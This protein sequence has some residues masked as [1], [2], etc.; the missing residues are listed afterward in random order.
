MRGELEAARSV[1]SLLLGQSLPAGVEAVY[2]PA[3]EVGGDLY[4]AWQTQE[5]TMLVVGDVSGKGL[6]AAMTVATI[7][8]AI[9]RSHDLL[10][11]ELL[12]A[13]NEAMQ[14]QGGFV[15]CCCVLAGAE[16]LRM[17]S[18]GHPAP[19]LDGVEVSMEPGLPLGVASGVSYD[20][21]RAP[22]PALLT[23]VSDGVLEAANPSGE[24]FGFER[25]REASLRPA[26][27]IAGAARAWG[28]TDDITVIHLRRV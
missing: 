5:G 16:Q 22:R 15:T 6:Q 11:G 9:R 17:A 3:S 27:E 23:L 21:V 14:G 7:V 13:L 1:Q 2:Y 20:E 19:Y 25:T 12:G 26:K 28:Q 18:A 10:P 8:G 4:Q 24:L